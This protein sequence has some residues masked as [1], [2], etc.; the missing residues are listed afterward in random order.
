MTPVPI[1]PLTINIILQ[2]ILPPSQLS[3]N[4]PNHLAS[5]SLLQRH[6]FLHISPYDP[7][8]YLCWPGPNRERAIEL[9]EALSAQRTDGETDILSV[10]YTSDVEYTYAHVQLDSQENGLRLVF[11][12]DGEDGWKYHDSNLMPFPPGSRESLHEVVASAFSKVA[13]AHGSKPSNE[14][15][16]ESEKVDG[17]DDDNYW[18]AYGAEDD[19]EG[20]HEAA[21]Q[22]R[23]EALLAAAASSEDAY[24]AQYASVQGINISCFPTITCSMSDAPGS[25]DSTV[26][27]PD[28]H[29]ARH[30][31]QPHLQ[32]IGVATPPTVE[33][34]RPLPIPIPRSKI[35]DQQSTLDP[36]S[37]GALTRRLRSISPF[38]ARDHSRRSSRGPGETSENS[39]SITEE[40][41]G[42]A[43][44]DDVTRTAVVS[45]LVPAQ[46]VDVSFP[47]ENDDTA[48][49]ESIR[50]VWRLWK[51]SRQ[52]Q[53]SGGD[54]KELFLRVTREVVDSC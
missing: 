32:N 28:S 15:Y 35:F 23:K 24:W 54:D 8:E 41:A 48:L 11:Q 14:R 50:S 17:H 26:P 18:N 49:K 16:S 29:K 20:A 31:H 52:N 46:E 12:W 22:A 4:L 40:G 30:I 37:P 38:Q 25:G 45:P 47:T 34:P 1:T 42:L 7:L 43:A 36:P 51:M 2:Y 27:S 3:Q 33:S 6:H 10:R 5:I 9:L 21:A 13:G 39:F 44:A 19:D 53:R